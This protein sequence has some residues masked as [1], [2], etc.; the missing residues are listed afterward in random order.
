MYVTGGVGA[1]SDGEAF[2]DPYELPNARAYGESCAAIGNMMWNWRMLAATG[3][4]KFADVIERALYNGINSG[5]SLDGTLY[6]YR[7][8]LAFDPSGGDKIRDDWYDT[9][10]CRRIW[11]AP[12]PRC[13][14]I[15]IAQQ[16]GHL[17][18]PLRQFGTRLAPRKRRRFEGP[19][20]DTYPWDGAAEITIT[21]PNPLSSLF[22]SNPRMD[23]QRPGRR[24]RKAVA[25]A[26]PA[27]IFR[28]AAVV[29]ETSSVHNS[30]MQPSF[31]S[32]TRSHRKQWRVA[33]QRGPLVYCLSKSTSRRTWL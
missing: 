20:K 14:G 33:V 21:P 5:M 2:G 1:R 22:H 9:T 27:S 3:E 7:N 10:C 28:C 32:P 4:A 16:R 15:S 19:P 18:P 13:R 12:L 11:S 26:T 31:W 8:P 6:C 25:G 17:S 30:G 29:G 24:Q 23:R